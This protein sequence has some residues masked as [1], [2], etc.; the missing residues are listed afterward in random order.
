M[1]LGLR[2]PLA[3]LLA[4]EGI[5][6]AGSRMSLVALPWFVLATTGS[7]L[8]TGVVAF[9][10][11]LPYVLSAV[12]AAPLVDRLGARRATLTC[13][14][15]SAVAVGAIP[16]LHAVDALSFPLL[17]GLV[18]VLGALRGPG[19]NAKQV[20]LP[21]VAEVV[22]APLE[23]V[24]GLH[25][26][27]NRAGGLIGAPLAGVLIGLVGAPTVLVVDAAT[28]AAAAL[29]IAASAPAGPSS[30]GDPVAYWRR[31]RDGLSFLRQEPLLLRIALLVLV[32]NLLDQAFGAVLLPVWSKEGGY[33]ALG[34]GLTAG[35]LGVGATASALVTARAGPRLDRR[36]C[37]LLGFLVAGAP[38][39]FVAAAGVPL[40]GLVAVSLLAGLAAG[41]LNPVIAAVELERIPAGLRARVLSASLAV[42]Y[43][44]IPLGGL[45]GGWL[46]PQIG[47]HPTLAFGG[48]TYFV[49]TLAPLGSGWRSLGER[50]LVA[51]PAGVISAP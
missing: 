30:P 17:L 49:A 4:A 41:V 6:I 12:L 31:L 46:V 11:M 1:T 26:T 36:R 10:E 48:L 14:A 34:V 33:G 7:P 18:A 27:V 15:A 38:R 5:S 21:T 39:W 22:N 3:G 29:I 40:G 25:D 28:F 44:G 42:S 19:D 35:A 9:A 43:A 37:I 45:V 24:T 23:R 51:Q 20:L 16:A 47:L 13:D 8:R 2:Q 32:T 50:R